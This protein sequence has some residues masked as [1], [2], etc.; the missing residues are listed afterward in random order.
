VDA[1]PLSSLQRDVWFS[2]ALIPD[3]PLHNGGAVVSLPEAID[4]AVFERAVQQIVGACDALRL[5]LVP[6]AVPSEDLPRQQI[7]DRAD[8]PVVHHDLTTLDDVE[9]ERWLQEAV[10]RPFPLHHQPLVRFTLVK[11]PGGRLLW[12]TAYHHL[13]MDAWAM[14]TVARRVAAAYT[15]LRTGQPAPPE[16]SS[17]ASYS[18]FVADDRAYAGSPQFEHDAAFWQAVYATVPEPL[19]RRRRDATLCSHQA[20]L[21]LDALQAARLRGF[22]ADHGASLPHV[23]VAALACWFTRAAGRDDFAVG[24]VAPL[25]PTPAFTDTVGPLASAVALWCR[26]DA[27]ASMV[28]LLAAI[29]GEAERAA[30]HQRFPL[31][32][33][34]RRIGLLHADR[35]RPFD[36]ALA[37]VDGGDHLPFDGAPAALR[38]IFPGHGLQGLYVH[39]EG[40]AGPGEIRVVFDGDAALLDRDDVLRLPSRLSALLAEL[41]ARPTAPVGTLAWLPEAERRQVVVD[42][43]ATTDTSAAVP[44]AE[45][46]HQRFAA[47]ARRTPELLAI[48]DGDRRTSYRDLDR[49]T[50][51]IAH[52]LQ[53]RGVGPERRVALVVERGTDAIAG[54][55]AILKAGGAYVPLDPD[56]PRERLQWL[57]R[58]VQPTLV[59]TQA[60]VARRALADVDHAL[61]LDD[62]AWYAALPDHPPE[63]DV[64][65]HHLAYVL[66]TSG[67]SGRPKGVLVEHR[68][69]SNHAAAWQRMLARTPGQRVLQFAPLVF[70][71]S[72]WELYPTLA[73]GGTLYLA[74]GE[75]QYPGPELIGFLRAHAIQIVGLTPSAL[76]ALPQAELPDLN[77]LLVGGEACP[78]ELVDRWAPGRQMWNGYGPTE[79]TCD[80]TAGRC[81]AGAGDPPIGRPLANVRTYL[82]DDRAQPVPIGVPGE[83]YVAGIGVARGYLHRP[84]LTAERFLPD[85]FS[86]A[87]G[88]RLYRTGDRARVLADGSLEYVGR[89]DHQIKLRGYRIELGEIEAALAS[90]PAVAACA[91]LCREDSPG[92][93]RLVAYVVLREGRP[94]TPDDLRAHLAAQLPAY[95][96][97]TAFVALDA[98]PRTNTDKVD[99]K[100][101]PAPPSEPAPPPSAAPRSPLEQI[102]ADTFAQVLHRERVG[103]HDNFFALG[104]HSLLG[105]Q[106]VTRL[107]GAIGL[108]LTLRALFE[109]P[110]VAA[111]TRRLIAL[112]GAAHTLALIPRVPRDRPLPLSF[113]QQRLWFLDRLEPGRATY[114]VAE[115][116]R[117]RGPLDDDALARALGEVVRRHEALRTTFDGSGEEP[118][119]VVLPAPARW[120]LP[121]IEIKPGDAAAIEEEIRRQ[122]HGEASRAFNLETGPVFRSTLLRVDAKH[123]VLLLTLHHILSDGW[124][125]G[126]LCRELEA[127][128]TAF[129]SGTDGTDGTDGHD[130]VLPVLP[131]LAVQLADVSAWQRAQLAGERLAQELAYWRDQLSDCPPLALPTDHPRPRVFRFQGKTLPIA[132]D[133]ALA[134]ALQRLAQQQGATLFMVLMA[135]FQVLLAR[136]SGQDDFCVGWPIA[137]R[138]REE[139]EPLIGF[140]ANTLVLRARLGE[141]PTFRALLGRVRQACLEAYT[142]QDLPFE[143]LVDDL[144]A[145]R[146]LGRNSIF[147]VLLVLQ[148][149]PYGALRLPGLEVS[150]IATTNATAKFDLAM[151]FEPRPDGG[152]AGVVEY[153]SDLFEVA[154]IERLRGH[155]LHLLTAI[156]GDPEQPITA[157]PLLT[158]AER[159]QR[160]TGGMATAAARPA[161]P[162]QCIHQRF[163]HHAARDPA[164]VAV[165][166]EDRRLTYG[167]LDAAADRLAHHLRALGV[168]PDVLVGLCVERSLDLPIGILGILK[169]GGAYVPLDPQHPQDRLRFL[170]QDANPAV[171][172]V[173]RGLRGYLPELLAPVVE[174]EAVAAGPLPASALPC[175]TTPAHLAYVLYTSGSTGRP[176]GVAVEHRSL[177]H[178]VHTQAE[179]LDIGPGRR[180][181]Q[182]ASLS[183]DVSAWEIFTALG[184]G[185]SLHLGP[186]EHTRDPA[187]LREWIR[188][189]AIDVAAFPAILLTA[190]APAEFPTLTTVVMGG[191]VAPADTTTA[192]AAGRRLWNA[193]GPTEATV[194]ATMV[195]CTGGV[196]PPIIGRPIAGVEVHV[197]DRHGEPAPIGVPGELYIGGAGLARGYLHRPE[198]T[199][200]KFIAHPFST[201]PAAR[202]YRTGDLARVRASGDLEF[203]GRVD[204]QV[205]LHGHRIE[206]GEIEAVLTAHPAVASG[207]VIVREDT[208]GDRRLVGYVVQDAR[209]GVPDALSPLLRDQVAGW[210]TIFEQTQADAPHRDDPASDDPTF[211]IRGWTESYDLR[212]IPAD[213]MRAWRDHSVQRIAALAPERIWEIG[214]GSGLLV[215]PL[216]PHCRE[217]LGTDF[218][219]ASLDRLR[220]I[221]A[222]RGLDHVRLEHREAIACDGIPA[223][224][225]DVVVLNS[226]AQYFPD[227]GYLRQVLTGAVQAVRPGGAIFLG[228]L[229]N[230]DLLP[231]FHLSIQRHRRGGTLDAATLAE[232]QRAVREEEELLVA[233]GYLRWL[234]TQIPG[235]GHADIQ[236]RRGHGDDE[237]TRYRYD[238]VLHV[239]DSPPPVELAAT[240]AWQAL[241]DLAALERWLAGERPAVATLLGVPNARVHADVIASL[242]GAEPA[243]RGAAVAPEALWSLGERLGYQVRVRWS[244]AHGPGALD[245][246]WED[247]PATARPWP[248]GAPASRPIAD[249][250]SNPLR[251]KQERAMAAMLREHL[252]RV[253]PEV[254]IPSTLLLLD[255]LP[256]TATGKVDR[257]ALPAPSGERLQRHHVAP[258]TPVE[259]LL[260]DVFAQVLGLDRVSIHENFFSLGG[261]SLLSIRLVGQLERAG[262]P[263]S[264][265]E[266]FLHPT[267][268]ELARGL[269]SHK[270]RSLAVPIAAGPKPGAIVLIPAVGGHLSEP[271]MRLAL[272]L[273]GERAILGL[274]TPPHA[275]MGRVPD[276]L[277][278]LCTLYRRELLGHVAG[279]PF[280]LLG[281]C[282]GGFGALELARQLEAAGHAVEQVM[283]L[284]TEAPGVALTQRGAFDRVSALIRIADRWSLGLDPAVLSRLPDEH[285]IQQILVAMAAGDGVSAEAEATLR[286]ILDSQEAQMKML[287]RWAP[288]MPRA[289]IHLLRGVN[290]PEG[291]PWDY[292]W[293]A[294]TVLTS[295]VQLPGDHFGV[296]RPPHVEA[297]TRAIVA[298]LAGAEPRPT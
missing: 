87:P 28:D 175:L 244:E 150:A 206:L 136:Y 91:V 37:C 56:A 109:A 231:A 121:V 2:Q 180:M 241:G 239:G 275:G 98:L 261:H 30:P 123:H 177:H 71:A 116:L 16:S 160:I 103:L 189:D 3:V 245:V 237:M 24:L 97:P 272:S 1:T 205:K 207:A 113:G 174:L 274:T 38:S 182:F 45:C 65:P 10:G 235:L 200:E 115:A 226:V 139:M 27:G 181:L 20:E 267:V 262:L 246:L 291:V 242:G 259:R 42:W 220:P 173:Q 292:G 290:A 217:Y 96:L 172:V 264:V 225:F 186:A 105:T 49:W 151:S 51:Q 141:A 210:R 209:A 192:W 66:Y 238:A 148:N 194:C 271:M 46:V 35:T 154:T 221:V 297:T 41:C 63:S 17:C 183:F 265:R 282:F 11:R 289:A 185:A 263:V 294:H 243:D 84:D 126:V 216:A 285:V 227:A 257:K 128:Y 283:L 54:V 33:L 171:I 201:D 296:V 236:L 165:V 102:V 288:E 88:A 295:L 276:T 191:E 64:G 253:L 50:N 269:G 240:R 7:A 122:M 89:L 101:L 125:I 255:A 6:G 284:E 52:A 111:L 124:S 99:R 286:A 18:D 137:N 48:V 158:A 68:S 157:L 93:P 279:G 134:A 108:E 214:C 161:G 153:A 78:G 110:T 199:R 90:A 230:H 12:L 212:P 250:V 147:Q 92:D 251:G 95:M 129:T 75:A 70:D 215:F 13:V 228:D 203:L 280:T 234:C 31:G 169:A 170:L 213:Q 187:A 34:N 39:V 190:L 8:V 5:V 144:G 204:E 287:D 197:L 130:P 58:D 9:A 32:E 145:S 74:P 281:Y 61:C 254:M 270:P 198:L 260:A 229:R 14:V 249:G 76:A 195:E 81:A 133:P 202:L 36:V 222:A 146:D 156:A 44:G 159:H 184:N 40:L 72:L 248:A 166:C 23:L 223:R 211:D 119:Q 266:V 19:L 278:E 59:L 135:A 55:L 15:A 193:Y 21:R 179:A 218:L 69:A 140:F 112:A 164:A 47:Q 43:N 117:L 80:A 22:A 273:G 100:A 256:R 57:L 233:P 176:K 62:D 298:L 29:R 224:H 131:P 79:A 114:N 25:R 293:S 252:R 219:P 132:V 83:L 86:T 107:R 149:A 94:L 163:A 118:A 138:T 82:L 208:P 168:G 247:G 73:S 104:G 277:E 196:V 167:E 142:H 26:V 106:V 120:R 152:L 178:L 188:R 162:D 258:R 4:V 53:A 85:P 143:R 268:A 77:V 232:A 155:Y 67:S 127:F 60:R